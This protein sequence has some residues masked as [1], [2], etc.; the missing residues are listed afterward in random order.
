MRIAYVWEQ[1]DIR[2]GQKIKLNDHIITIVAANYMDSNGVMYQFLCDDFWLTGYK[3]TKTT[4]VEYLN[5]YEAVP[6]L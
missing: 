3:Y 5:R 1:E 6:L 4:A 2:V